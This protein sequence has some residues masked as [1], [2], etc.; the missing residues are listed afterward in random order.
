MLR[1]RARRPCSGRVHIPARREP[2]AS[3]AGAMQ[4]RGLWTRRLAGA[5]AAFL[6]EVSSPEFRTH[7]RG[8]G[9]PDQLVVL[10]LQ[11]IAAVAD[12]VFT[13]VASAHPAVT[14]KRDV[15]NSLLSRALSSLS[16]VLAVGPAGQD[17]IALG[18]AFRRPG[19][20]VVALLCLSVAPKRT[21]VGSLL[22]VVVASYGRIP[23]A[24]CNARLRAHAVH[25][26]ST[27]AAHC[28]VAVAVGAVGRPVAV[29]IGLVPAVLSAGPAG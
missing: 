26:R 6:C 12:I 11:Y 13:L 2:F 28:A 23:V 10:A 15:G 16:G 8:A 18:P 29:V 27:S 7:I 21:A 19:F 9:S 24:T 22:A 1:I 20:T 25:A 3:A 17:V 4:W 14:T 5:A